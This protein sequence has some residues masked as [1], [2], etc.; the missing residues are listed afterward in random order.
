MW[1]RRASFYSQ[2]N[3]SFGRKEARILMQPGK[4]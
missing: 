1:W 3:A 2:K 4:N